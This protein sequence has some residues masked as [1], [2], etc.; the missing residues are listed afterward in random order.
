MSSYQ[1]MSMYQ[2]VRRDQRPWNK[3]SSCF[4]RRSE[5]P[6]CTSTH[7]HSTNIPSLQREDHI[8]DQVKGKF[9]DGIKKAK[10]NRP[11]KPKI[12][13]SHEKNV[14]GSKFPKERLRFDKTNGAGRRK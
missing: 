14:E 3:G 2:A 7:D 1:S 8:L 12:H 9:G 10:R 5:A 13:V 11:S 4:R 6:R